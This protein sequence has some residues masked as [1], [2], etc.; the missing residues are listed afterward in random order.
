MM[1]DIVTFQVRYDLL[2]LNSF[3][4]GAVSARVVVAVLAVVAFRDCLV[5]VVR[6][7]LLV[8]V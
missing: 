2:L 4:L 1:H 8:P 6:C 3:T 7:D 5:V